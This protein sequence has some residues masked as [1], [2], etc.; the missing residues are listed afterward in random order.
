MAQ[1]VTP[2]P[3]NPGPSQLG[4]AG[5]QTGKETTTQT[6]KA[7]AT[8]QRGPARGMGF[9]PFLLG[10][11]VVSIPVVYLEQT[12]RYKEAWVYTWLVVLLIVLAYSNEFSA[13]FAQLG[14]LTRGK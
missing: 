12:G 10:L 14:N 3:V 13:F 4:K 6:G 11:A 7:A 2:A 5:A 9:A 1:L 8:P